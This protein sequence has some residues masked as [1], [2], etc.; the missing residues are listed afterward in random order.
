MRDMSRRFSTALFG[1]QEATHPGHNPANA[2]NCRPNQGK[3][4]HGHEFRKQ[5]ALIDH[6]N[7]VFKCHNNLIS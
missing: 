3:L 7:L 6:Y 2:N 5:I 1:S 4:R